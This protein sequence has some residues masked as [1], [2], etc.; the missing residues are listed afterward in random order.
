MGVGTRQYS[1]QGNLIDTY[2][3][4]IKKIKKKNYEVSVDNKCRRITFFEGKLVN[5]KFLDESAVIA[6]PMSS[7]KGI[8]NNKYNQTNLNFI[9]KCVTPGNTTLIVNKEIK[10]Y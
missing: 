9:C 8:F 6:L 2:Q 4:K 5:G 3:L 1:N 7:G 10:A